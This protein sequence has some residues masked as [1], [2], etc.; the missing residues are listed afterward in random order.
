M[1]RLVWDP[2]RDLG[3]TVGCGLVGEGSAWAGA[4]GEQSPWA[5]LIGPQEGLEVL[6][7]DLV[8]P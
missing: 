5:G 2:V 6:Q 8:G 3:L 7:L 4:G 1:A